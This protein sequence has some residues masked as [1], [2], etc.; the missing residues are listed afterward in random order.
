VIIN[1]GD[2]FPETREEILKRAGDIL[3]HVPFPDLHPNHKVS[4][5][6]YMVRVD[7]KAPVVPG[8]NQHLWERKSPG[9]RQNLQGL[10]GSDR[11]PGS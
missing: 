4:R 3:V 6:F 1:L 9:L 11:A 5:F 2:L 7:P 10:A 8:S